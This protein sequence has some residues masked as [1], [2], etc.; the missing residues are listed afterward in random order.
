MFGLQFRNIHVV[1]CTMVFNTHQVSNNIY[2]KLFLC[3]FV[4][5][6]VNVNDI[7]VTSKFVFSFTY[8][9][10]NI[11]KVLTSCCPKCNIVSILC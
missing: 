11:A 8:L 7:K 3:H 6:T 4:E 10:G 1:I 2:L 9:S 5:Q